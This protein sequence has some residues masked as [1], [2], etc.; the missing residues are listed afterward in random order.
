[1]IDFLFVLAGI[2]A[3]GFPLGITFKA[4][5]NRTDRPHRPFNTAG[6]TLAAISWPI[7]L[8]AAVGVSTVKAFDKTSRAN[9]AERRRDDEIIE[10]R[11]RVE[12]AKLKQQEDEILD[13]QLEAAKQ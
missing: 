10:A 7:I 8:P 3:Y 2:F 9:K 6:P 12:I 11:H 5:A 1:M 13:R 4:V